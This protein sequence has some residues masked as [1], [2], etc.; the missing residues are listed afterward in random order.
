MDTLRTIFALL[1]TFAAASFRAQ[2]PVDI[3]VNVWAGIQE[4]N[5]TVTHS[6]FDIGNIGG[7]FDG[8]PGTLGRSTAINPMIITLSFKNPVNVSATGILTS[9]GSGGWWTLES[10]GNLSDLDDQTG[11]YQVHV[12]QVDQYSDVPATYDNPFTATVIRL[13]VKRTF[14]AVNRRCS[15]T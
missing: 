13:S 4:G 15:I 2:M 14:P 8:D 6:Q 12:F 10:A 5:I 9:H 3:P 1:I 7:V 11:S